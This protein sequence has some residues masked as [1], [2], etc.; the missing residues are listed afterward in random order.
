MLRDYQQAA[1]DACR[2][3]MI[4]SKHACPILVIPTGG[5]K[6][7]VIADLARRVADRGGRVLITAHVRELLEQAREKM[8]RYTDLTPGVIC[9]GLSRQHPQT[10]DAQVTVASI[11]SLMT[12]TRWQRYIAHGVPRLVLID[13]CHLVPFRK[14]TRYRAMLDA[15]A[16][17]P[18]SPRIVGLTATPYRT[19]GGPLVGHT[20]SIFSDVA[21][22][23]DVATLM[24]AG[25]LCDVVSAPATSAAGVDWS[26]LR[27]TSMGDYHPEDAARQ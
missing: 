6:T 4:E 5:G 17:C 7:H 16:A 3:R 23:V 11:Q 20:H 2:D 8:V 9:A 13:E 25:H 15:F 22:E 14:S 1:V 10:Y 12:P 19:V 27:T 18:R 21:Y 24:D 26:T